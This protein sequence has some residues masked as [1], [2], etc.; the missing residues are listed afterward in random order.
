[1]FVYCSI[2]GYG[3]INQLMLL[4]PH[5]QC[6]ITQH[7][8]WW[9]ALSLT[10]QSIEIYRE[11]RVMSKLSYEIIKY[12][13]LISIEI[14]NV[15]FDLARLK[16]NRSNTAQ[17]FHLSIQITSHPIGTPVMEIVSWLLYLYDRNPYAWVAVFIYKRAQIS[18]IIHESREYKQLLALIINDI[19]S[20]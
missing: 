20:P 10:T 3:F 4:P 5:P 6:K 13:P 16:I 9:M 17:G 1:M 2:G 19:R 14:T 7:E 18:S 8:C 11:P 12:N 15:Y